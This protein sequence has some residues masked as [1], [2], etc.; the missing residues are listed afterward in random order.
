L[1]LGSEVLYI[2]Y[3]QPHGLASVTAVGQ[4]CTMCS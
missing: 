2:A 4:T 1:P 3:S